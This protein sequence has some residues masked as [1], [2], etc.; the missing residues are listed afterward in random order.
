VRPGETYRYAMAALYVDGREV[1]S[2]TEGA[3]VASVDLALHPNHPNPFN[4]RTTISYTLPRDMSVVLAIY[5]VEGRLVRTLHAGSARAG[6]N[7]IEWDGTDARGET[8][9]SGIYLYRLQADKS[10]L[11]RKMVL[12]K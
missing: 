4:P 11:T 7:E 10:T 3:R 9:S 12:L 6:R 2:A 8:V 5:D 1:F